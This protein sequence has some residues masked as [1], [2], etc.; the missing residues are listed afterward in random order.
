MRNLSLLLVSVLTLTS[1]SCVNDSRRNYTNILEQW[2]Q[3][4]Q[5][6]GCLVGAEH[7]GAEEKEGS[8]FGEKEWQEFFHIP[9][10]L[11]V[12]F[13][14]ERISSTRKIKIHVCPFDMATE[15]ELAVYASEQILK[16]NWFECDSSFT[17]LKKWALEKDAGK[18]LMPYLLTDQNAQKEIKKYF[19]SQ[20]K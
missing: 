4:C 17:V 20:I 16:T 3:L 15:G 8:V 18:P 12:P 9:S 14:M 11:T 19:L 10:S 5:K 7:W 6:D 13:L 1:I 2:I